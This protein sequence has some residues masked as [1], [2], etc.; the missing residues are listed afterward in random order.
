MHAFIGTIVAYLFIKAI[1][2]FVNA[3]KT[4]DGTYIIAGLLALGL[5]VW[6]IMVF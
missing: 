1:V 6:G 4:D 5:A 3:D 2:Q